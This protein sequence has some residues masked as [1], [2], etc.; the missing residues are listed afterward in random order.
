MANSFSDNSAYKGDSVVYSNA[1][2][3]IFSC[4]LFLIRS[5]Q[6]MWSTQTVKIRWWGT[7][8]EGGRVNEAIAR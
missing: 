7:S 5:S 4:L 3:I 8:E 6:I 1:W 2:N